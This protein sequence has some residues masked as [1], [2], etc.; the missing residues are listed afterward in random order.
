[1]KIPRLA[2]GI[3]VFAFL[4]NSS[5]TYPDARL[6]VEINN[7]GHKTLKIV[8]PT[9][10]IFEY[11]CARNGNLWGIFFRF[12]DYTVLS[13]PAP[14]EIIE[15][16]WF[17]YLS[18]TDNNLNLIWKRPLRIEDYKQSERAFAGQTM[19]LFAAERG[20]IAVYAVGKDV[21]FTGYDA[22]GQQ[23]IGRTTIFSGFYQPAPESVFLRIDYY[24]ETIYFF[25]RE[26]PENLY[27]G[28]WAVNRIKKNVKTGALEI[29]KNFIPSEE[30]SYNVKSMDTR[31]IGDTLFLAWIDGRKEETGHGSY[32]LSGLYYFARASLKDTSC[33]RQLLMRSK[34]YFNS[35]IYFA[36]AGGDLAV[37][38][39]DSGSVWQRK[40]NGA[41]ALNQP[42]KIS[43]DEMHNILSNDANGRRFPYPVIIGPEGE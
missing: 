25:L 31:F 22:N 6:N 41:E 5:C 3:I 14:G 17:Y 13:V 32:K 40:I 20:F 12:N 15:E 43:D 2:L 23:T 19:A 9:P 42:D 30:G 18:L 29:V 33:N 16:R 36:V 21:Y 38:M 37:I 28:Q 26:P 8:Y 10:K 24:N 27:N 4:Y 35:D 1:M 11:F 7:E 34:E 39:K